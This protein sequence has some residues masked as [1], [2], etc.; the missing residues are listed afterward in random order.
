MKKNMVSLQCTKQLQNK[1]KN[2]K[3]PREAR[4]PGDQ[5]EML[6]LTDIQKG[7]TMCYERIEE[8]NDVDAA[9]QKM[10]RNII[11]I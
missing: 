4:S 5:L 7:H 9:V 11:M 3:T 10:W 8:K 6:K 1:T 2:K